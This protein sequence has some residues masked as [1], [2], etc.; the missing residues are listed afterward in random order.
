MNISKTDLLL[1]NKIKFAGKETAEP[2]EVP[3]PETESSPEKGMNALMFQGMNNLMSNPNLAQK[4]GANNVAFQGKLINAKTLG[5]SVAAILGALSLTNCKPDP[6]IVETNVNVN[7]QVDQEMAARM[8]AILAEL[9]A[10]RQDYNNGNK[11]VIAR[12]NALTSILNSMLSTLNTLADNDNY[13]REQL[14]TLI[15]WAQTLV[16][17]VN[18]LNDEEFKSQVLANQQAI[19]ALLKAQGADTSKA[20]SILQDILNS[21]ASLSEKL[22]MIA[23]LLGDIKSMFASALNFMDKADKDKTNLYN[24]VKQTALNTSILVDYAQKAY[25]S[26]S[27]QILN[28]EKILNKLN[29]INVDMNSNLENLSKQLGVSQSTIISM[30]QKI[31]YTVMTL[32]SLLKTLNLKVIVLCVLIIPINI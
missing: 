3:A 6:D 8:Q 16:T 5:M 14:Q 28:Q 2:T 29:V 12:L 7:V 32:F 19:I 23:G 18:N 24:Y 15:G 13:T 17:S 4:V 9:Q 30:L 11:E 22:D 10:L 25:E 27:V 21:N 26:D 20:L 31:G 1:L